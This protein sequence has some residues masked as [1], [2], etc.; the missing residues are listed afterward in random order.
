M[1]RHAVTAVAGAL[2]CC[3]QAQ[4]QQ[5]TL[6]V[7]AVRVP[8][9]GNTWVNVAFRNTYSSAVVS[10]TYNLPSRNDAPAVARVRNVTATGM[11]VRAQLWAPGGTVTP[12]DIHCL[13]VEEGV[14]TLPGGQVLE[15]RRVV[16]D[17]T[18]GWSTNWNRADYEDVT[19]VFTQAFPSLV[20]IGSPMTA[21]DPQP[22]AFAVRGSAN[23]GTLPTS[24]QFFVGKHIGQ[25]TGTRAT[26]TLGVIATSPGAGTT[27]DVDYLFG[28]TGN[29][30]GGVGNS[31][32]YSITVSGDFSTGVAAQTGEIGGQ[33]SFAVLYG[34]D[35]LPANRLDLALDEETLAGDTTRTHLLER[36]AYALFRDDQTADLRAGKTLADTSAYALPDSQVEY[37]LSVENRGNAPADGVFLVDAIPPDLVVWTGDMGAPG[38]GPV[39]FAGAGTG[40]SLASGDVGFATSAPANFNDC[41][42]P[43]SG[44]FDASVTHL[45]I[46]PSGMLKATSLQGTTPAATFRFRTHIR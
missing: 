4:A 11:E 25:T 29:A 18:T 21:N 26:E 5:L 42:A 28:I 33:G 31:P 19:S 46:R 1:F 8:A 30:V 10:C 34:S 35:P 6:D 20:V 15:A 12:S 9:V 32:P 43:T 38:S 22:S 39:A 41:N 40:L 45:C 13:V 23:R 2:L 36:V 7:E 16:S 17:R 3:A 27:N 37:V 14:R 44:G 24:A